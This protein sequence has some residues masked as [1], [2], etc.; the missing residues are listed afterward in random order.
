MYEVSV[1][2]H[3]S[4]AHHLRNYPG[5]CER[6]HGHNWSVEIVVRCESTDELGMAVDFRVVKSALKDVLSNLDHADL[7][8]L[9]YFE[10]LNPSSENIA[11]YIFEALKGRFNMNGCCLHIVKVGETL[12]TAVIYR[13]S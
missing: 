6:H 10:K 7:N 9:Q 2:S 4:A 11:R 1:R 13:E 5:N 8:E 12:D 3:F